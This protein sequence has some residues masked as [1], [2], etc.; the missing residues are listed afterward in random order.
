MSNL[1]IAKTSRFKIERLE[2]RIAPSAFCFVEPDHGSIEPVPP[3]DDFSPAGPP[4]DDF[5]P[6]G[7][8]KDDSVPCDNNGGSGKG[9]SNKSDSHKGGSNKSAD[10]KCKK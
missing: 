5:S 8:P 3:K 9:G 2:D 4:K 10:A 1:S 7:P 6:A